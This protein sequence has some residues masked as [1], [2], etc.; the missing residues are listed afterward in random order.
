MPLRELKHTDAAELRQFQSLPLEEK[1]D[2]IFLNGRETN[3]AVADARMEIEA[4]R[5]TAD[6][7]I[8]DALHS[9]T[10]VQVLLQKHIEEHQQAARDHREEMAGI[11]FLKRWG[12][13]GTAFLFATIAATEGIAVVLHYM[14]GVGR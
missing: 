1:L 8:A 13:R 10:T 7:G 6:K 2:E 12:A 11:N 9:A 14:L 5:L 4:N 3:G